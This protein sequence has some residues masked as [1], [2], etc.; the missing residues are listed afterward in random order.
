MTVRRSVLGADAPPGTLAWKVLQPDPSLV[1]TGQRAWA[2]YLKRHPEAAKGRLFAQGPQAPSLRALALAGLVL[3]HLAAVREALT[4]KGLA[5]SE[6]WPER[7]VPGSAFWAGET[8]DSVRNA[9]ERKLPIRLRLRRRAPYRRLHGRGLLR[10]SKRR[11]QGLALPELWEW[12]REE[13]AGRV[14]LRPADVAKAKRRAYRGQRLVL[15]HA[16]AEFAHLPAL[17]AL[18]A[19]HGLQ[20]GHLFRCA[21]CQRLA[22]RPGRRRRCEACE[23]RARKQRHRDELLAMA[24][25]AMRLA[26]KRAQELVANKF[27]RRPKDRQRLAYRLEDII[28]QALRE[29]WSVERF[30]QAVDELAG[31]NRGRRGRPRKLP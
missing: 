15:E 31:R 11:K 28:Q 27:R 2:H 1:D 8:L 18:S 30:E 17:V 24:S 3:R 12:L 19:L 20:A 29:G 5:L 26:I 4:A 6:D 25:D 7:H 14:Q 21:T 13:F 23:Q 22:F 9:V 10:Q 16:Q